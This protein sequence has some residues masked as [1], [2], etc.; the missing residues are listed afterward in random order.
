MSSAGSPNSE[1]AKLSIGIEATGAD[2]TVNK[3]QQ[4]EQQAKQTQQAIQTST[5]SGPQFTGV[6]SSISLPGMIPG[7]GGSV[8]DAAMDWSSYTVK[9]D[10][11]TEARQRFI[12]SNARAAQSLDA[13]VSSGGD[14][15]A[16]LRNFAM[17]SR[18]ASYVSLFTQ[19]LVQGYEGL[20]KYRNA[21]GDLNDELK[22]I[23]E[24]FKVSTTF[25]ATEAETLRK[26]ADAAKE[27]A[28]QAEKLR[29]ASRGYREG[30]METI[31][32]K[33]SPSLRLSPMAAP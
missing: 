25:G 14:L 3:L 10:A 9:L 4:V 32:G 19:T 6:N 29:V 2:A 31:F 33:S 13:V 23:G 28:I 12:Q 26:Q 18:V 21:A 16:M 30:F 7:G 1:V 22:K 27:A 5:I 15:L 20:I 8:R 11:A 24:G 17:F